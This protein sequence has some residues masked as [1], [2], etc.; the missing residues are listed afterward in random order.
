MM[1]RGIALSDRDFA[2][3][4]AAA[5][6]KHV[7]KKEFI[8]KAGEIC[9]SKLFINHGFLRTYRMDA[10]GNEHI[11][12][13]SPE[14]SWT[15]EGESYAN[16]LPS[17]YYIE[18]LEDSEVLMW[19]KDNFDQLLAVIPA[20]KAFSEQFIFDNLHASRN[21]LYKAISSSPEEK[22]EEFTQTFPG[23]LQ[24]VPLRMVA[25]YLGVSLKTLTRIR[26]AQ[27]QR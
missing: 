19:T 7:R 13:F 15:T 26:Q 23:I 14:L 22:Y 8:L 9:R 3:I 21:R 5:T 1:Q 2:L 18:A 10:D 17:A 11:L 27:L 24:R 25:S 6:T 4:N 20:L 12:Q 16:V